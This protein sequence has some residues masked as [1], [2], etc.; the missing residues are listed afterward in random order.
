ME[1]REQ[2][3]KDL[4]EV[5]GYIKSDDLADEAKKKI[6]DDT[7]NYFNNYVS[8]GW[9]KYRKSVSTN[10]AVVEW[11]DKGAYC[12]GLYGE[13]FIDCL[14]GFGIYTCGHRN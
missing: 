14:G 11:S 4:E 3:I 6:T 5:I 13:K 9:L 2:V 8:P 7:I 12:S 10:A 1:K